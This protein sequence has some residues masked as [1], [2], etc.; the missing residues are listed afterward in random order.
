MLMNLLVMPLYFLSS[1]MFPLRSAP[2]WMRALM[3]VDP[4]SYGVDALRNI[5]FTDQAAEGLIRWD[6]PTDLAVLAVLAAVLA[7]VAAFL[8]GGGE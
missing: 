2:A 5:V 3:T 4:L 1:A 7:S 6:L 8:F